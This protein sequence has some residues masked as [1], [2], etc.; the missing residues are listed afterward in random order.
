MEKIVIE[1]VMFEGKGLQTSYNEKMEINKL[2][3]DGW[4]IKELTQNLVGTEHH[5]T[6]I[7]FVFYLT[8]EGDTYIPLSNAPKEQTY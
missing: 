3:S 8:K 7:S 5:P 2:L 4:K 1:T 6:G